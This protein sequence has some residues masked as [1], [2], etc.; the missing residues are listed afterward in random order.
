[1]LYTVRYDYSQRRAWLALATIAPITILVI[2]HRPYDAKL[3]LLTIPACAML[4]SEGGRIARVALLL[5]TLGIVFTSDLP[6]LFLLFCFK[7]LQVLTS[8][9]TIELGW[10]AIL[11]RPVPLILLAMT[12]FYLWAYIKCDAK[13]G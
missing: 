8:M 13:K 6:L 4:H 1:L 11:A 5:T 7:L 3:L 9:P 10:I 12:F 2:Y